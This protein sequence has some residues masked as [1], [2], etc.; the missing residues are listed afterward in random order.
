MRSSFPQSL[1][2]HLGQSSIL[3]LNHVRAPA[4]VVSRD[5]YLLQ[6]LSRAAPFPAVPSSQTG[7]RLALATR[8]TVPP[9]AKKSM[10]LQGPGRSS[11]CNFQRPRKSSSSCFAAADVRGPDCVP[12]DVKR[13]ALEKGAFIYA[14]SSCTIRRQRGLNNL[15]KHTKASVQGVLIDIVQGIYCVGAVVLLTYVFLVV[16]K[17]KVPLVQWSKWK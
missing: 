3:S 11:K 2:F 16:Y 1:S 9:S 8:A 4:K 10:N 14:V 17:Y 5:I 15:G 13:G 7:T 12:H 6:N